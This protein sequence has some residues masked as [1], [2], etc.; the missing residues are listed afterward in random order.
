AERFAA[1]PG[2]KELGPWPR[3]PRLAVELV[4]RYL[5]YR[6][7]LRALGR[8]EDEHVAVI[9]RG[10]DQVLPGGRS[11][12]FEI[13]SLASLIRDW[14]SEAPYT[15]LA[16]ASFLIADNLNDLH[17]LVANNPRVTRVRVPLP[18]PPVLLRALA[19]LRV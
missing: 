13:A 7:N 14:A 9:F 4:S 2:A 10:A 15:D 5:R 12:D 3:D 17:P 11:G 1:W 16:F 8:S 19:Q 18:E 6:A